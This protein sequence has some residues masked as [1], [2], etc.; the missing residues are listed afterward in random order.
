MFWMCGTNGREKEVKADN[1]S[2][3]RGKKNQRMT[4]EWH[5]GDS[6]ENYATMKTMTY[7]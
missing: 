6:K 5:R 7:N 2:T 3:T 4:K 1:G